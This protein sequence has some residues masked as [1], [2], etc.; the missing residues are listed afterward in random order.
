MK[1]L[2]ARNN[3][4]NIKLDYYILRNMAELLC[5]VATTTLRAS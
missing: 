1:H 2:N 3:N 5:C 4:C